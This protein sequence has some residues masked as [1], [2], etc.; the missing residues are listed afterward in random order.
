MMFGHHPGVLGLHFEDLSAPPFLT[1]QVVEHALFVSSK[2]C[3]R[4]NMDAQSNLN[5][6]ILSVAGYGASRAVIKK[7]TLFL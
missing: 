7:F 1:Q 2:H 5:L 6:I 4:L 3:S